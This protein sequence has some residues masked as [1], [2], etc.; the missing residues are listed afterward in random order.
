MKTLWV[1]LGDQ[2]GAQAP[3]DKTRV[4]HERRQ[5]GHVVR[6]ALNIEFI[7][8]ITHV[9]DRLIAGRAGSDDLGDHWV[10]VHRH[11][12][13]FI[14]AGVYTHKLI[15]SWRHVPYQAPG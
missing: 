12:A 8:R 4:H 13:A 14:D 10:V 11:L 7:E 6:H 3:L 2:I 1:F 15:L 5:K 9:R